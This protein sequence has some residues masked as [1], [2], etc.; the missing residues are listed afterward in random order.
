MNAKLLLVFV[1]L[2]VAG[3]AFA[4]SNSPPIITSTPVTT[5]IVEELYQYDVDATDPD[6]DTILYS[7][8]Q[9]PGN[10]TIDASTGLISWTPSIGQG[11][12]TIAVYAS[13]PSGAFAQQIWTINVLASSP[14]RD[15]DG[16]PDSLDNCPDDHNPIGT[17]TD[18]SDC[19][20]NSC[21]TTTG[22]CTA[23][24]DNDGD[25][26]GDVCDLD[27]DNDGWND[28]VDNCP[29][30]ANGGQEDADYDGIGDA[31]DGTFTTNSVVNHITE[32]ASDAVDTITYVN[33]P[34]G[35]GLIAKL[36]GNGGVVTKV[37]NAVSAYDSGM[38]DLATYL[39]ELKA[40]LDML[41]AFDNQLTAKINSGKIVDPEASKLRAISAEIKQT[42]NT[43]IANA[44]P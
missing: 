13:D 26:D 14:D 19:L 24:N 5:A 11:D 12:I 27:D 30:V 28:D 33:P 23:Q 40:A 43:L 8:A 21:N 17:C 25:G 15:S 16:I 20:G 22:Y 35:N 10:M 1:L 31:C 38:I 34:G 37:D 41:E 29:L 2:A 32:E 44:A 39:S 9:W 7:L 36:T 18:G 4:E 6:G 3:Q 42:I